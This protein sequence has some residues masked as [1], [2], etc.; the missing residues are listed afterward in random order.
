MLGGW[1]YDK[2]DCAP[3]LLRLSLGVIFFA[4]GAQKVLGW[5]GGYGWAGTMQFFTQTL[6]IPATL[7][8]VA[9]LTEFLGG[10][11]LLLGFAT[12]WAALL[13]AG[14]M[15]VAALR[16]HV[17]NGFFMNWANAPDVGH[18]IEMNLALIGAALALVITGSGGLSLDRV[19]ARTGCLKRGW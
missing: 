7:A 16:V 11:A 4:H 10:I 9:F 17:Q 19:L 5:F 12:R 13:I 6:H 2:Q 1:L 14:E 3:L 8:A 15:V 18:G